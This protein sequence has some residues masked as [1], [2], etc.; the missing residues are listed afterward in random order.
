M[1]WAE[2]DA[3]FAIERAEWLDECER[4]VPVLEAQVATLQAEV[5]R[6]TPRWQDAPPPPNVWVWREN[7]GPVLP[8]LTLYTRELYFRGYP[9]GVARWAP[10]VRPT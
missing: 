2:R 10:I 5:E 8:Y 6:L 4:L 7:E 1:G 9:W 3:D